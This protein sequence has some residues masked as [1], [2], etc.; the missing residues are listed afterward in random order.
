MKISGRTPSSNGRSFGT[1]GWSS[2][3]LLSWDQ[4]K[5]PHITATLAVEDLPPPAEG[6]T[7]LPR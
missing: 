6:S 2:I 4:K 7:Y 3:A 1:T 5:G